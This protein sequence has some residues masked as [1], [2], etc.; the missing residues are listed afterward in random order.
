MTYTREQLAEKFG[1]VLGDKGQ[2][3]NNADDT[4]R[5]RNNKELK[6]AF[7]GAGRSESDW[8]DDV[9]MDNDI[10]FAF[11]QLGARDAKAAAAPEKAPEPYQMSEELASAKAGVKAFEENILPNQ[12]SIIMGLDKNAEGESTNK[13]NFLDAYS[14]DLKANLKPVYRDGSDRKSKLREEEDAVSGN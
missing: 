7:L 9:S 3:N 6:E 11:R 1:N 13:Q 5:L 8:N 14:L 10:D 4:A 2:F 12:G